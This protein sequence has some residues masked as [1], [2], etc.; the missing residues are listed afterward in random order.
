[1]NLSNELLE[2]AKTARTAEEL[3]EIAKAENVELTEDEAAKAFSKLNKTGELSDD[4]LDNVAGGC[5]GEEEVVP[6]PKFKVGELVK[7]KGV[8]LFCTT[9][10]VHRSY[11]IIEVL[12]YTGNNPDMREYRIACYHCNEEW[13]M[14]IYESWLIKR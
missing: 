1:M 10:N 2:K 7:K 3:L 8:P 5:G 11:V 12:D 6:E 13:P 9:C 14:P 4:E